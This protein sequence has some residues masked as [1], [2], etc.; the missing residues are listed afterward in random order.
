MLANDS[1]SIDLTKLK[2]LL[3]R[4]SSLLLPLVILLF[5]NLGNLFAYPAPNT[6]SD[7]LRRQIAYTIS[8][9]H[10]TQPNFATVSAHATNKIKLT[11]YLK[12][13]DKYSSYLS[14]EE[15]D[16]F[17]KRNKK[18]RIGVGF[19]LLIDTDK[20]LAVPIAN[21][22]IANAGM[23]LSR[24]IHSINNNII[25]YYDF[26]SYRFLNEVNKGD[27]ITLD[28]ENGTTVK[29]HAANILNKTVNYHAVNDTGII[30]IRR[31]TE[32]NVRSIKRAL[33]KSKKLRKIIF[34]LRHNPGGDLYATVDI[35]SFL[36][37]KKLD[38]VHL[39]NRNDTITLQS[40]NSKL[41]KNKKIFIL[42]S[43]FTAS[44]AEVFIHAL[45][46]YLPDVTLIGGGTS[47][48]CLAQEGLLLKNGSLLHLSAYKLLTPEKKSC[49]DK[50]IQPDIDL[51]NIELMSIKNIIKYISP[52]L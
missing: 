29:A 46:Y 23:K 20:I 9:H 52:N 28:L 41:I 16:F 13:L 4:G 14:K 49:Q 39:N 36:L 2:V 12:K 7:E 21:T 50:P 15:V 30:T 47:G 6:F 38:I 37:K 34:D 32:G 51:K 33:L 1:L 43:H 35:L 26:S 17:K 11:K 24:Y 45:K 42:M 18:Q 5:L 44:S 48:K 3:I 27:V 40:L 19:D 22:P 10:Y 25:N 8:S 31:F